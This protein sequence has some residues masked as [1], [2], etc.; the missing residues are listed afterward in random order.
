MFES[1]CQLL[2]AGSQD[3]ST[4]FVCLCAYLCHSLI[5]RGALEEELGAT[6]VTLVLGHL[7]RLH[8]QPLAERVSCDL[9]SKWAATS[10]ACLPHLGNLA[11]QLLSTL[12][13]ATTRTQ[14]SI[15][16]IFL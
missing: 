1:S 14:H 5:H 10:V 11:L 7:L 8:N 12:C 13:P 2:A 6:F 3:M 15:S 4:V 9:F 16:D